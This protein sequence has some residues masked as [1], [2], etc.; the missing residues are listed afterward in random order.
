[1][2]F[3]RYYGL[4][5]ISVF[6]SPPTKVN[7]LKN[8]SLISNATSA[9]LSVLVTDKAGYLQFP[10]AQTLC[11]LRVLERGVR[12]REISG[13]VFLNSS[14]NYVVTKTDQNIL[15]GFCMKNKRYI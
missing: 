6:C 8:C 13:G 4:E 7:F 5:I 14:I 2:Y 10:C 9:T 15:S 12:G 1:M 11:G 3:G